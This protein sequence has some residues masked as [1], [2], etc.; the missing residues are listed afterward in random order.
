[1]NQLSRSHEESALLTVIDREVAAAAKSDFGEYNAILADDAVFMLPN[2][3]SKSGAEL[4]TW[5]RQ[6]LKDFVVEWV[7]FRHSDTV[8]DGNLG[9][10]SYEFEW[11]VTP[12]AGG[13]V[14][15]SNGKGLHVLRRDTDGS[16][17]ILREIWNS[18]PE[19]A[20]DGK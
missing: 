7:T 13:E 6:F 8:V 1:M 11:K 20:V 12:R 2:G 5:L 15:L 18:S 4:R 17:K 10:H 14:T 3:H 19:A 16:W 9:Y